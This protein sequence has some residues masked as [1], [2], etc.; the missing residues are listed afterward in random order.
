M[1]ETVSRSASADGLNEPIKNLPPL[2]IKD[3]PEPLPLGKLI[4]TS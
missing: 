2:E 4:G 3:M 1:T